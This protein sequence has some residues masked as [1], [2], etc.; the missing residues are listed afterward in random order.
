MRQAVVATVLVLAAA[1]TTAQ[2][3]E[4]PKRKSGLWEIGRTDT[5]R[6]PLQWCVDEKTDNALNQLATGRH[7]ENC[8]ID[9]L[10][11]EGDAWIVDA[12]CSLGRGT[13]A[14]THAVVTG[15]FDSQYKIES[16]STLD[17]PIH[18]RTES[19]AVIEARWTGACKPDQQPGDVILADGRKVNIAQEAKAQEAKTRKD[20]ARKAQRSQQSPAQ[21]QTSPAATPATSATP[22]PATP[23]TPETPASK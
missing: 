2:A 4:A 9:T 7:R 8:K 11:R 3:V 16:T 23:A 17:P 19:K 6:R 20:A 13:S 22:T 15:K 14:K 18:G 21:K 5:E 10:H 12:V 1:F